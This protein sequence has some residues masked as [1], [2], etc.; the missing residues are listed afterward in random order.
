MLQTTSIVSHKQLFTTSDLI[1]DSLSGFM[2]VKGL[3]ICI[4]YGQVFFNSRNQ[5]WNTL[6]TISPYSFFSNFMEA[7]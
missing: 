4:R 5:F 6:E 3:G 2:P 7:N 1:K